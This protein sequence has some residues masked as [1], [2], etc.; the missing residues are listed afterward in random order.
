MIP[1]PRH[2]DRECH[3]IAQDY[4]RDEP[5]L[6][7]SLDFGAF[8]AQGTGAGP[9]VLIGDQSEISL[10]SSAVDTNLDHRMALLAAL[11]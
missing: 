11:A 1:E 2:L 6:V 8:V 3:L 9:S 5:A 10:L 4:L 7:S